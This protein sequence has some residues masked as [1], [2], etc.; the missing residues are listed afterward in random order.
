MLGTTFSVPWIYSLP[1]VVEV[2]GLRLM[3]GNGSGEHS[4]FS[5]RER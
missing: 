3:A 4:V 2:T 5:L 1:S